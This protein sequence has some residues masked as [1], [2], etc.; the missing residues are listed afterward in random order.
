MRAAEIRARARSS[1][2]AA[3][4]ALVL[5]APAFLPFAPVATAGPWLRAPG[6]TYV[7][8][9]FFQTS[10]TEQFDATGARAPL[11]DPA[12]VRDGRYEEFGGN[13]YAE[14]GL[15]R[16]VTLVVDA[17]VKTASVEADGVRPSGDL[18][19][20]SYGAPDLRVGARVPLSRGPLIA[21]LEASVSVPLRA[22]GRTPT[23]A[24]EIGTPSSSFAL[25]A[26]GGGSIPGLRA[27]AQATAGYRARPGREPSEW[28]ADAEFGAALAGR[29][30]ARVRVDAI[31]ARGRRDRA[32]VDPGM[33]VPETGGQDLRRVAPTLAANVGGGGELAVTWRRALGGR[34]ALRSTEWELAY[35]FVGIT[36][37][38]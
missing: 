29:F 16:D 37:S 30:S 2:R 15:T 25:A 11:F 36:R 1:R 27:Y 19:G 17:L 26:S 31:D 13:L 14:H 5:L 9:A 32:A 20:L 12:V 33:P 7:K 10:G 35:S 18:R 23:D 4:A 8:A 34:S 24:P 6:E 21:A 3:L 22:V 38:R 28:L